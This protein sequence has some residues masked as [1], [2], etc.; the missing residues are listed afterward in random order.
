MLRALPFRLKLFALAALAMVALA[1]GLTATF[2]A[3]V[4][5]ALRTQLTIQAE[6]ARPILQAAL[7]APL[8]ERDFA[9]IDAVLRESVGSGSFA[10]M[11]LLDARGEPLLSVGWDVVRDGLPAGDARRIRMPNGEDRMLGAVPLALAGQPLGTLLFGLSCEPIEAAHRAMLA[12]G[13]LAALIGLALLVPAVELGSRWIARPLRRLEDAVEALRDGREAEAMAV[14]AQLPRRGAGGDDIARL[15]AA[16]LEM[17][18]ALQA[19]LHALAASDQAQRILLEEAQLR[20]D[21]LREAIA[22]AEVATRAKSQFLANISHEVRTPLN[23]ILGMAQ[24]LGDSDLSPGDR[25]AVEVILG[26]G[27]LLLAVIN[28]ILDFSTLEAG[29]LKLTP[30][31]VDPRTL[32]AVPLAPLAAQAAAKGLAWRLDLDPGLPRALMAD[33]TR[34]AQVLLNLVSN[35]VKFTERGEVTVTARW[36]GLRDDTDAPL[37]RLRVEVRDSGIGIPE[38]AFERL[39]QRFSQADGSL[40]RRHGGTGLGLA[41]ARQLVTLMGG[42]I[43]FD[44][45]VGEGSRFWFEV[46]LHAAETASAA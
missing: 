6:S 30:E 32:L 28:D 4:L 17:A 37:G 31:R 44:S 38:E 35:A 46:P 14:R 21:Q 22:Q 7:A 34:V 5:D 25:E 1:G 33:R 19:R 29:R 26:S 8:A 18:E 23:G 41:I 11:V 36:L 42:E 10:H 13:L 9:T 20:E 39:F 12:T 15:T 16:Y 45:R 27:Q 3:M 24:V 40:Q 43:G 2:D